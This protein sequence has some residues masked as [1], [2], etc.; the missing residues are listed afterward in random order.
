MRVLL[1]EEGLVCIVLWVFE[2]LSSICKIVKY[3]VLI[4]FF[5]LVV[6]NRM[7]VGLVTR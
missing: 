2:D 5:D 4:S 3:K 6:C 7:I 1:I